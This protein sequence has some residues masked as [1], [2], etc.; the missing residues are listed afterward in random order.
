MSIAYGA[1][2][3]RVE[4]LRPQACVGPQREGAADRRPFG[5]LHR[6]IAGRSVTAWHAPER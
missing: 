1:D 3:N 2:S 6:A 5:A 4:R